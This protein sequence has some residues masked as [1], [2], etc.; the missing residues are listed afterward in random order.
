[1]IRD[2][3]LA[4]GDDPA[5]RQR[6]RPYQLR[7]LEEIAT[8]GTAAA[9]LHVERC[10]HCG[11]IRMRPN[12]CGNRSCPHCQGQERAAWVQER[13]AE[14]LPCG[15]VHAVL[16][17]PPLLRA[18]AKAHPAV[19]LG[20]LMRAASDA[21]DRLCRDPRHL[22]AQVGQLAV[23]HTWRR[24]LAWHPHVHVLVTA[25]GWDAQRS[26][27]IPAKLYGAAD[28]AFLLPAKLLGACF[29]QRLR[30]LLLDAYDRGDFGETVLP[31]LASR[32]ALTRLL[33]RMLETPAVL[34]IQ[35][36]FA[37]PDTVLKYLGAYINRCAISPTRILAYDHD[38]GT[39]AYAWTTNAEPRATRNATITAVAFLE[40][41]A[42][43]ILPTG[44]HRIRFR[45]LWHPSQRATTLADARAALARHQAAPPPRDPDPPR[46]LATA[47][48]VGDPCP[49]CR[50]GHYSRLPGPRER[51]TRSERRRRLQAIRAE[52]RE[53]TPENQ[54]MPA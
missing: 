35:P 24:D 52:L 53:Q 21:I 42:Q 31:E 11:D 27:W 17:L 13:T 54:P 3:A 20:C 40:R 25:G 28:R 51:L 2:I 33:A 34:R 10:D 19:G 5:L 12:T 6:L 14:L 16:T 45:G 4:H 18:L 41:F 39:V 43:H 32:R 1:V 26:A 50:I 47:T 46:P 9:G 7:A 29:Q 38:A 8:C 48:F 23:L 15:Y 37:G 44:F 49:H 30:R 36:P 22:G